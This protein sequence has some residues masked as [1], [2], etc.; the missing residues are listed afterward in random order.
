M[1]FLNGYFL[2]VKRTAY[3]LFLIVLLCSKSGKAQIFHL[4]TINCKLNAEDQAL[5]NRMEIVYFLVNQ[6]GII[7]RRY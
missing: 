4:N 7:W 1:T 2:S 6:N 5:L 3:F